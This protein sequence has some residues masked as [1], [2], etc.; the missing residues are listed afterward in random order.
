M[1]SK[2]CTPPV[3]GVAERLSPW[4]E[5]HVTVA[6]HMEGTRE[7]ESMTG[8]GGLAVPFKGLHPVTYFRQA[9]SAGKG[10]NL[11]N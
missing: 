10:L 2:A 9:G 6:V 1:L 11:P 8:A 7:A 3:E 5:E 4:W